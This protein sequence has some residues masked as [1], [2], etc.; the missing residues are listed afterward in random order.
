LLEPL[1]SHNLPAPPN[2]FIGRAQQL[3]DLLALI[4]DPAVR[5]VTVVGPGGIGKTRLA[6][7]AGTEAL[8]RFPEGVWLADLA[9]VISPDAVPLVVAS[10]LGAQPQPN[11]DL[12]D[13]LV[14]SLQTRELLLLLDN[15]EHVL[16]VAAPLAGQLLSRCAGLTLLATSREA[17]RVP[18]EQL[19]QALPMKL[20]ALG[21]ALDR[22]LAIEAVQLFLAR[23]QA[24]R[25]RFA[26]TEENARSIIDI[27][28]RLDGIPLAIELAAVRTRALAP[29]EIAA[30]L[31]DRFRLLTAGGRTVPQ[32]QQTL[33]NTVAWS[34][35]LLDCPERAFFD[36]LAVFRSGFTLKAA[37]RV[38]AG[39][40]VESDDVLDLLASLVDKSL[41]IAEQTN[42]GTT[43]YRLLETLRQFGAQQLS[44]RNKAETLQLRH[45]R[46]FMDW[47]EELEPLLD[48]W[49]DWAQVYKQLDPESDNLAAVMRWSLGHDQAEI[50][51]R[52]G[53]ALKWWLVACPQFN[54]YVAWLRRALHD[55]PDVAPCLRAKAL[56]AVNLYGWEYVLFDEASARLAEEELAAAE[57]A[58]EPDLVAQALVSMGRIAMFTGPQAHARALFQQSL[59]IG[60]EMG[61]RPR[62]VHALA[63]IAQLEEQYQALDMLHALLPET[64]RSWRCFVYNRL[65][66]ANLQA[67]NLS[68]AACCF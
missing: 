31:D 64:P 67:G 24:V 57:Q 11:R 58:Q 19:F 46:Y 18:G 21:D 20:P 44:A 61:S 42:G 56:H 2:P 14:D 25:P 54:Q 6:L 17:L 12:T 39:D 37:E 41:V 62:I 27:C 28:L 45:A 26:L 23:A 65:A 66:E 33:H 29:Q 15:C 35:E 32:R 63:H 48:A 55:S 51:L 9:R 34:Y 5:L 22:L 13:T 4:S 59:D 10:A 53:G 60:R 7:Q 8:D 68:E 1:P 49:E 50:A 3:A 43:R 16:G 47:V 52:I 36:R 40:G 38:C 30:R